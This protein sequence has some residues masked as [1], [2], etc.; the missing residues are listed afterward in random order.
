MRAAWRR[1]GR[2]RAAGPKALL[3]LL[4]GFCL[5]LCLAAC[6]LKAPPQPREAV[7]PMPVL[8]LSVQAEPAGVRLDFTLP[9]KSLDGSPLQAIG[10]Y[11]IVGRLPSG[12]ESREEV[13]FSVS[14]Q[15]QK[16]GRSVVF[17]DRLPEEEG[18]YWYWVLPLDAYGS[19]PRRGPGVALTWTGRPPEAGTGAEENP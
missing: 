18:T 15:K 17:Y 8:D 4:A 1:I 3:W 6:G 2:G 5:A 9:E 12:R 13:R 11:R 10:G 19:H 7:V 16:V 14:E